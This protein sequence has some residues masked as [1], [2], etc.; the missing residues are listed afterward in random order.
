MGRVLDPRVRPKRRRFVWGESGEGVW[1]LRGGVRLPETG[2]AFVAVAFESIES[3][4]NTAKANARRR[5][6]G[7]LVRT[8]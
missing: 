6:G 7:R 4:I 1:Q 3:K 5:V 8:G 2:R